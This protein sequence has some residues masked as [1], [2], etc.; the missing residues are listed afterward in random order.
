MKTNKDTSS[1]FLKQMFITHNGICP[2][3]QHTESNHHA[4]DNH[5][6]TWCDEKNCN[7]GHNVGR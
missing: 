4:D 6:D 1:E 7:C 5:N 2:E 3:C